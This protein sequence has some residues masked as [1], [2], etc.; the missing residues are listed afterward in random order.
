[1][2]GAVIM[3]EIKIYTLE[4]VMDI[5]HVTQRTMYRY[6]K[7]GKLKAVKI[8]KYWRVSPE[9]LQDFIKNGTETQA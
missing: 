1:M 4:E 3:S 5:L 2:K 6:I 7:T 9:A 8:G